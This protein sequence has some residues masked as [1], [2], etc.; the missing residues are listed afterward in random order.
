[1]Q[2]TVQ[3]TRRIIDEQN[4]AYEESLRADQAKVQKQECTTFVLAM[5]Y[6]PSLPLK[7]LFFHCCNNVA[8][9]I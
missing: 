9:S 4:L 7:P 5:E 2:E 6:C 1:M 3:E 8:Y